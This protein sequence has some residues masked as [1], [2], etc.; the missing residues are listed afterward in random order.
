MGFFVKLVPSYNTPEEQNE[1]TRRAISKDEDD[2]AIGTKLAKLNNEIAELDAKSKPFFNTRTRDFK[3][4]H[5]AFEQK[6]FSLARKV[7]GS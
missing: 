2:S 1:V 7:T 4:R 5:Y 6:T 3:R